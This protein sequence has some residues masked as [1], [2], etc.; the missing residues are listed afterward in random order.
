[1]ER[2]RH[3]EPVEPSGVRLPRMILPAYK[4]PTAEALEKRRALGKAAKKL[5]ERIGPLGFSV[6]DLIREDREAR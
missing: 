5:R 2:K 4:P 6:T 1:M 3:V